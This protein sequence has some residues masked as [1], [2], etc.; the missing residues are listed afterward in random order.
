MMMSSKHVSRG[1]R[2]RGLRLSISFRTL[3]GTLLAIL[4]LAVVFQRSGR[5][6]EPKAK[7]ADLQF[8][9]PCGVLKDLGAPDDGSCLRCRRLTLHAA[10][11]FNQF[12][13]RL[14]VLTSLLGPGVHTFLEDFLADVRRQTAWNKTEVLFGSTLDAL[15]KWPA[16]DRQRLLRFVFEQRNVGL[17]LF[18]EDP[19]LYELWNYMISRFARGEFVTNANLDDRRRYD[20]WEIKM[21]SLESDPLLG[22]VASTVVATDVSTNWEEGMNRPGAAVWFQDLPDVPLL[23]PWNFF[24]FHDNKVRPENFPHNSPMWRKSIH[25]V[26]GYFDVSYDPVADF[27]FWLRCRN[28]GVLYTIIADPIEAYYVNPSSHNRRTGRSKNAMLISE[29]V[30][31]HLPEGPHCEDVRVALAHDELQLSH[32]TGSDHRVMTVME[33]LGKVTCSAVDLTVRSEMDGQTAQTIDALHGRLV[34]S[35]PAMRSFQDMACSDGGYLMTI[36]SARFPR[37]GA[38]SIP[39]VLVAWHNKGCLGQLVVISDEV[40]FLRQLQ[41]PAKGASRDGALAIERREADVYMAAAQ[42]IAVSHSDASLMHELVGRQHGRFCVVPHRGADIVQQ[43]WP[44]QER[45]LNL[46]FHGNFD[47]FNDEMSVN[48][49]L[50]SVLPAVRGAIPDMVLRI[51]GQSWETSGAE[52]RQGALFGDADVCLAEVV[53]RRQMLTGVRTEVIHA[54]SQGIPVVS[55]SH[56]IRGL[57]CLPRCRGIVIAD[58]AEDMADS[59]VRLYES[60]SRLAEVAAGAEQSISLWRNTRQL[61][62]CLGSIFPSVIDMDGRG[63]VDLDHGLEV[64]ASE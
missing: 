38:P 43:Q 34:S 7:G 51:I 6:L 24:R 54:L 28:A 62:G 57:P 45:S 23:Q 41:S 47:D 44:R 1:K 56:G 22:V 29:I 64:E 17:V 18:P 12:H 32:L 10:A 40:H 59:I 27:E 52:G 4:I 9:D 33:R 31:R 14:S 11:A 37:D 35:D 39:E 15:V 8:S 63:H 5:G 25:G 20:S 2:W 61:P 16:Q 55:T 30:R 60:P 3:V 50:D 58:N 36:A 46:C 42:V 48:W 49:F 53:P 21:R 13:P 26:C 19:G